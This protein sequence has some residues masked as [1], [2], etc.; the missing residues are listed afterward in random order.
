MEGHAR[1]T[2]TEDGPNGLLTKAVC[3][4][5]GIGA[6]VGRDGGNTQQPVSSPALSPHYVE[7]E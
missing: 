6:L 1:R 7:N 3:K 5:G 4:I 2:W